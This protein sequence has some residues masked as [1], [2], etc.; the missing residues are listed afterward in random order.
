MTITSRAR[1]R[2][3]TLTLAGL[4]AL[5]CTGAAAQ[6]ET[7]AVPAPRRGQAGKDVVWIATPD[8]AVDRMLRMAEVRAAD[9]VVDL[10]AGDGRI[11]IAAGRDFGAR[12]TGLEFDADLVA[13]SARRAREAGVAGRVDFRRADIFAT[14]FA[15]ATVV[16]M[17]LLP[18]LN[19]RLRPVLFRMA[20]G[21]RVVSHSFAMGDWRPDETSTVGNAA[22]HLWR[23]PA[24]AAGVWRV[25]APS[26]AAAVLGDAPSSASAPGVPATPGEFRFS[27]RFQQIEGDASFGPLTA[28]AIRPV[29]AGDALSFAVRDGDGALL[30]VR[31]RIAGDRMTGTLAR[32][33]GAA[34]AF[35]AER[36][37]DAPPIDGVEATQ[38]ERDAAARV[39]N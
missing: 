25:R 7:A 27:Q 13:L 35:D 39:L 28:G 3:R 14:D 10:G 22:L 24:N 30:Q 2:R 36:V 32:E 8:A 16:T 31:A 34:L 38:A 9:R 17:Y 21:T 5:A 37:G 4:L 6:P 1:H 15:D 12:A 29:L 26:P 20:P 19:L 33:T 18:E 11:A 23:V